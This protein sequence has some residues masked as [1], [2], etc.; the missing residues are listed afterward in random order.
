MKTFDFKTENGLLYTAQIDGDK[1]I[2]SYLNGTIFSTYSLGM[3]QFFIAQG[4]WHVY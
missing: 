1:C 3:A 4:Y 2:V